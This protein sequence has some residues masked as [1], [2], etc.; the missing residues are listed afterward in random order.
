MFYYPEARVTSEAAKPFTSPFTPKKTN[1]LL[2]L[3][4]G[5]PLVGLAR[6]AP[7][8][9]PSATYRNP[10]TPSIPTTPEPPCAEQLGSLGSPAA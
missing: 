3:F 8:P 4:M 10:T 6:R 2:H 1:A 9:E 5:S 7:H